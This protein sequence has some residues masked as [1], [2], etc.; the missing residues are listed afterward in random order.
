M[1]PQPIGDEVLRL[2]ERQAVPGMQRQ[3]PELQTRIDAGP[4]PVGRITS[5]KRHLE[6]GPE[7]LEIYR[8]RELLDRVALRRELPKPLPNIPEPRLTPRHAAPHHFQARGNHDRRP[9]AT[10]VSGGVHLSRG[11]GAVRVSLHINY[12]RE[13]NLNVFSRR[14]I[15]IV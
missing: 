7:H 15:F 14:L 8:T 9:H 12:L 13:D 3:H 4:A 5:P 6:I 11:P 10:L 2:V 1:C